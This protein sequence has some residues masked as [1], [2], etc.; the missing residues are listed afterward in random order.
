V[1]GGGAIVTAARLVVVAVVAAASLVLGC[2]GRDGPVRVALLTNCGTLWEPM[3]ESMT[4]AAELPL[5][6]RGAEPAGDRPS[7]GVSRASIAGRSVELVTGCSD[8][9]PVDTVA[10]A[11]KLVEARGAAVVVGGFTPP[12]GTALR[13]YARRQPGVMFV[14]VANAQSTTLQDPAPNVF[15]F[16]TD[17]AQWMAGLGA[18]AYRELG[19]RTAALVGDANPFGYAQA[20]GFI[21]EF[22]ALGGRVV[23]R[24]W[25]PPETS[26]LAPFAAQ[27]P[28]KADGVVLAAGLVT[29]G[30]LQA[31]RPHGRLA[32]HVIVGGGGAGDADVAKALGNRARGIVSAGPLPADL[33]TPAWHAYAERVQAAFPRQPLVTHAFVVPYYVAMDAVVRAL[34]ATGANHGRLRRALAT[35]D[36]DAPNGRVRLDGNRQAIAPNY[37]MR[38][39]AGAKAPHRTIATLDAVD[40]SFGG[41]FQVGGPVASRTQPRCVRGDPPPWAA[42]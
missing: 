29:A 20:A 35:T 22:C 19:W 8:G 18:Y 24:I 5:L 39:G 38:I 14:I 9:T 25:P 7:A 1:G 6:T 27:V 23:R 31:Y 28:P 41:R 17:A 21:A 33:A 15:R 40:Q 13:E 42:P 10:E 3:T 34:E 37:L 12:E 36:L 26:D 2:G 4:A 11:R 30:F 32:E 16:S